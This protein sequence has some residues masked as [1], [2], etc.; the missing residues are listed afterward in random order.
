MS[1]RAWQET[2]GAFQLGDLRACHKEVIYN[3]VAGMGRLTRG[4]ECLVSQDAG[5]KGRGGSRD[6]NPEAMLHPDDMTERA[7]QQ[8]W[9]PAETNANPQPGGVSTGNELGNNHPDLPLFPPS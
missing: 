9:Q 6:R 5:L 4:S 2:D 3:R 8:E 1:A 7:P